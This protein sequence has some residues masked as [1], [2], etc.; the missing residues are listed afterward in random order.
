MK[1]IFIRSGVEY[2]S[3]ISSVA[4]DIRKKDFVPFFGAGISHEQP[5]YL[6]LAA[7]DKGLIKPL[8]NVF[9]SAIEL[10]INQFESDQLSIKRALGIIQKAP[11]ERLLE[12][13]FQ[14][15]GMKIY[16]YISVLNGNVWNLNHAVIASFSKAGYLPWCI[17]LNFDLLIEQAIKDNEGC[18]QTV[19][20]LTND[21]F[22]SGHDNPDTTIIKPHGSFA[23]K[24]VAESPF[25]LLTATLSSI[26]ASPAIPNEEAV[27]LVFN[28][29][30]TLLVAGYRDDDWDIF[31]IL[32]HTGN[33]LRKVIWVEYISDE[34]L[35]KR[36][37]PIP[38]PSQRDPL[39]DRI[40]PWLQSENM[41][42]V[43][44][45]G[46]VRYFL[47]DILTYLNLQVKNPNSGPPPGD[48]DASAFVIERKNINLDSIRTYVSLA[49]LCGNCGSFCW[50]LMDW[51][52]N[53]P[54]LIQYPKVRWKVE[55]LLSNAE[56]T[57]GRMR[58]SIYH[59]KRVL[60]LKENFGD[61]TTSVADDLVWLGYKYLSLV[62]RPN[63]LRPANILRIPYFIWR[64]RRF[65]LAGAREGE[66]LKIKESPVKSTPRTM[67]LYEWA[68]LI[69]CLGNL[70]MLLGRK[71][72]P[73]YRPL[74][75][76]ATKY[77]DEIS[78]KSTLMEGSYYFL[79][80]L[81]G[82]LLSGIESETIENLDRKIREIGDAHLLTQNLVQ[83]G[84]AHAYLALVH[85][86]LNKD[87][88]TAEREL[89]T[90][91]RVWAEASEEMAS[92]QRRVLLFRRFLGIGD[93]SFWTALVRFM[94]EA[95]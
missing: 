10:A 82:R 68:D 65:M 16:E 61:D 86:M 9:L 54:I 43:L 64:G 58:K 67:A 17:T 19:C 77:H 45:L 83:I 51:L 20:P 88:D 38:Y 12:A 23:P 50:S 24:E 90:V 91:A 22:I 28:N 40:T 85:A 70:F 81:E 13:L 73:L 46:N 71:W 33:L 14:T 59:M 80:R 39:H 26:G 25:Q 15:H 74:F 52:S 42:S 60:Y 21:K 8:Q 69:L 62:K 87:T 53:H 18:C 44:L 93:I 79:R 94:R 29:C 30:S 55:T 11:L 47:L 31:P 92:G 66:K 95:N 6:P 3:L 57:R 4:S 32:V 84:N 89:D 72:L 2:D 75:A 5:S 36:L 56:H 78:R 48:P 37:K 35:A 41:E 76:L 34:D 1:T 49:M 63:L 7:G 27:K